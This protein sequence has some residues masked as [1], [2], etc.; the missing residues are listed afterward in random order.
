MSCSHIKSCELFVQFALNP[1]LDVWKDHYCEGS[2]HAAC[3]R[4]Q[5]SL[6][7]QPVPLTLLPNGKIVSVSASASNTAVGEIALFNAILKNR[8]RMVGS[9]L[10]MGVNIN[11]KNLQGV[12]PLLAA[13]EQGRGEIVKL[14]L[15]QGADVRHTNAAGETAY[16]IAVA[17]GHEDI[18]TLLLQHGA[19]TA[20]PTAAPKPTQ[21]LRTRKER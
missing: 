17:S 14:L 5:R 4:Y 11:A 1:A 7:G 12:T 2:Q 18:V 9:I 13:A 19:I 10:K 6:V 15:E 20:A 16:D 8:G 21:R 3:A